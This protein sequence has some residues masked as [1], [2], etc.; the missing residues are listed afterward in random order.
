MPATP[1]PL[2]PGDFYFTPEGY[3]VFTEQYHRRRGYCCKSGCRHCPWSFG[4]EKK[5]PPS[6]ATGG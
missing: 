6:G 4:R 5:K 2:H 1:Q 3:M